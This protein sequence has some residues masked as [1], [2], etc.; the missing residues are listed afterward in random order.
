MER[1][2]VCGGESPMRADT[3]EES[4]E[5]AGVL[6]SAPVACDVCPVCGETFVG[7]EALSRFELEAAVELARRG[8]RTGSALRFMRS[9]LGF[10]S[11]ELAGLLGV[12]AETFS[13]WETGDRE[14]EP[15]AFA[16]VGSLA[17]DRLDGSER[18]LAILRAMHEPARIEPGETVR[19]A[20]VG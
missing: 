2:P 11:R 3:C 13:R 20:R 17:A 12:V 6:F 10:R 9:A 7:H 18:M 14:P 5:I 8:H 15:R 4:R 16:L 19:L 1:C